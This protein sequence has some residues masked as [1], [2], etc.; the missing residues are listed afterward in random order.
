M[1]KNSTLSTTEF[2][3]W[4]SSSDIFFPRWIF[5]ECTKTSKIYLSSI[6]KMSYWGPGK[7]KF[8]LIILK[9][10]NIV[11]WEDR[12]LVGKWLWKIFIMMWSIRF[13]IL[14][15]YFRVW[16]WRLYWMVFSCLQKYNINRT[17]P[18]G[19]YGQT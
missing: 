14:V 18:E 2:S 13:L 19:F 8:S 7:S 5:F 17:C 15:T 10:S 9:F 3:F 1:T 11:F 4:T 12:R 16:V 6:I